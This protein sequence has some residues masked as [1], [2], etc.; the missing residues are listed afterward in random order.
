MDISGLL[1]TIEQAPGFR[2]LRER[3]AAPT[4]R[5]VAGLAD[6]AK[7]AALAALIST[8][9]GPSL[10][11][12]G[13]ASRA[14]QL[15]EELAAWLGE[16]R[17]VLL[18]PERDV[19]P[20]ERLSPDPETVRERLSALSALD[21]G[22]RCLIVASAH[23]V[24]QRTLAP[25]DV[26]GAV[27][28]LTTG[29]SLDME[30]LV[31]ELDRL[32][33][34][35]APIVELTGEFSRRGGIVDVFPPTADDPLRIE[36]FGDEIESLRHFSVATQRTT[37]TIDEAQIGPAQEI[38]LASAQPALEL[39]ARLN[40]KHVSDEVRARF[41]ED[42]AY[43]QSDLAFPN[44]DF[45]VP[46][47][48]PA[49]LLDHLPSNG[50]LIIDEV[51]D[52]QA[53]VDEAQEDATTSRAELEGQGQIPRGL[54]QPI[55]DWPALSA[56]IEKAARVLTLARW[57]MEGETKVVR[58]P[59]TAAPAYGGQLR[60]L[61][62][63]AIAG[64]EA[65]NRTVIVSQQAD[66]IA[67]LFEEQGQP[68]AVLAH[69]PDEP[70]LLSLVHGS[71]SEGWNLA[72]DTSLTLLADAEVFGFV[73]QRRT[74]PRQH[75]NREAFLAELI[76]GTYVVHI[77]HGIA[78]FHGL[79]QR[80]V[81]GH[82]REYLELHYAEGDRLFVPTDQL[83][84]VSRYIGPSDRAP[85]PTRLS[86]GEWQRAKQRVR[87]AVQQLAKDL[88][89][90]YAAREA[91]PGYAYP[92][93]TAWQAELEGS[94]PYVE[95]PDQLA[96]ISAVKRDMETPRPMD[97][98]V[99]GDVGY[100]KTEVA[101][102]AAFKAVMD[103]KQVAILVPTTVLAQQHYNTFRER[104]GA[105]PARVDV[106]S[107]F[108]SDAEQK[109]IVENLATG[110]VDIIIGTHRLLQKDIRFK[111]L[112][113]V[114]ID[115][116]QRFGVA[117]KEFLKHMRKEVDVLT[118]S[119]TPI[120]RTLYMSLGGIRD[121]STMETP[122]EERLPIKTYVAETEDRII[123]EAITRELER[124]GQVYFVHNRV[125]NIDLIASKVRDIVPDARIGIGHG[126]MDEHML[127]RAMDEFTQGK[128]DVLVCTT[129]IE[130]GLDI[131]NVNT[132]VIN[133]ADK[134]GLAQ[135][136]QLRGR[137]GRG[138]NRAY[139]Y[140]LHEKKGRL[141]DTARMRLQTIFEATELGA[142]FQIALRD[143]EIRGAGNLLGGEQSGYMS[144]IGFDLYV[145]LLANAVERYRSLMRGEMPAPESEGPDVTIDL[146]ISAH[147]PTT[148]VPDLNT[149]LALYQ[150]LS[151]AG[152]PEAVAA[153]GQEMVDRL[154][155]PPPVARNLMYVVVLRAMAR[156]V[157]V[158]SITTEDGAAV[159]RMREGEALPVDELEG[160]VPR[161]VQLTRHSLRV[162]LTEGWR[163]RLRRS[164]EQVADAKASEEPVA[165]GSADQGL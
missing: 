136:Y 51:S 26:R 156:L 131:P 72:G 117:H 162:E 121:M 147:L 8:E 148:Y 25:S 61:V 125:H 53:A 60:K 101:I 105:F 68:V 151:A 89:A 5:E 46:F 157:G 15:A 80:T 114:V 91:M 44:R 62:D 66:R 140:L 84:R 90:L 56:R 65:G 70:P 128:I 76:P 165:A 109:Q 122:P 87:K 102:R 123:R 55:E 58:L 138:S 81:D 42:V 153:I 20:F 160:T 9:S 48:A 115:E 108:R 126:Q 132:I 59:F 96:A 139:A 69:L 154:G 113:L 99:C 12:T 155:K 93:D 21:A 149:R 34:V 7:P 161:G 141:T 150:R 163:E 111:E 11:V 78:K 94:F 45:Y 3:L 13:R 37:Q 119:A 47:L 79:V 22:E 77:D 135:L 36:F 152:D 50:L 54:P 106:I 29:Q 88:L 40:Y 30:D 164:L 144:A 23:A 17:R 127:A 143:L 41:E 146:P 110:G 86:S 35:S 24:A 10:V 130:S 14:Q 6:A 49:T 112:G 75:V 120:P 85:S 57:A 38:A 95:T 98:L 28:T 33:Y 92:P 4:S 118:L 71:L 134:L 74:A 43:L 159:I 100:G 73:K 19:L 16:G 27:Q 137:V 124:G 133:Q 82:E 103:G 104:L 67:E 1:P 64:L 158:Q 63:E 52:L 83:D 142:G 39:L 32:G 18:F 97:R 129:I 2:D 31:V 145:K 107:R 116:E